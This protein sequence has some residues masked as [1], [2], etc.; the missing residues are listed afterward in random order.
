MWRAQAP[1]VEH[2]GKL[3]VSSV[4]CAS[5][6]L[7]TRINSLGRL[8]QHFQLGIDRQGRR[9]VFRN[10]SLNLSD[11]ESVD[12]D[13]HLDGSLLRQSVLIRHCEDPPNFSLATPS[14]PAAASVASKTLG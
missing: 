6:Y 10:F 3:N 8:A 5:R 4:T 1:P 2:A 13:W 7:Q 9:L 11:V 14:T 12:A